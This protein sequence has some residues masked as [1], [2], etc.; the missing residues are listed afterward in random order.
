MFVHGG[1]YTSGS[2][3]DAGWATVQQLRTLGWVLVSIDY[4][5]SPFATWPD[6]P[7]DVRRAIDWWRNTGATRYEAPAFPLVGVGWSAGGQLVEWVN[8]E[9]SGP[10]FDAAVSVGGSTWWPDRPE[11]D[12]TIALFG[13][14][15]CQSNSRMV[16]ASSLTH[17]DPTDPPLLHVH[18]T[19]DGS[20]PVEQAQLLAT[21]IADGDGDPSRHSVELVEGC[22]HSP[23]CLTPSMLGSFL[24]SQG[25]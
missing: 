19:D 20:V 25:F 8:L 15:C 16:Q 1:G 11:A 6:H 12:S 10:H 2:R 7:Q 21:A 22:G 24:A 17:L 3:T 4:E 18:G 9:D 13:L 5:L 23:G 14:P